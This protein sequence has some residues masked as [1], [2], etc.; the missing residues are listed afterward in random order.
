[1]LKK[2]TWLDLTVAYTSVAMRLMA[3]IVVLT[4]GSAYLSFAASTYYLTK[5]D[6]VAE[7]EHCQMVY[8]AFCATA[9]GPEVHSSMCQDCHRMIQQTDRHEIVTRWMTRHLAPNVPFFGMCRKYDTCFHAAADALSTVVSMWFVVKLAGMVL[10]CILAC[11]TLLFTI[12]YVVP[13]TQDFCKAK[14]V[15]L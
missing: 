11:N 3:T 6:V 9:T 15:S 14:F 8:K 7:R 12:R 13:L 1:M 2:V 10:L 5:A 4:V